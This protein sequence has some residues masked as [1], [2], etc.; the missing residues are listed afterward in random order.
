MGGPATIAAGLPRRSSRWK[1]S[2]RWAHGDGV[3]IASA[4]PETEGG[5]D[6]RARVPTGR[7]HHR[8]RQGVRA[9][10]HP[11]RRRRPG[12]RGQRSSRAARR[13]V[14][15]SLVVG[16]ARRRGWSARMAG[17]GIGPR[18]VSFA[19]GNVSLASRRG[20]R[21]VRRPP[22]G[23]GRRG[24][25]ARRDSNRRTRDGENAV[26]ARHPPG[27]PRAGGE[28]TPPAVS[29][30]VRGDGARGRRLGI[31]RVSRPGQRAVRRRSCRPSRAAE[32]WPTSA[33]DV[34]DDGKRSRPRAVF[35]Q[36]A[37]AALTCAGTATAQP[38]RTASR[39]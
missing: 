30:D 14:R 11:R 9:E 8:R 19:V 2:P 18:V 1:I 28:T 36:R 5:D 24:S 38:S 13:A 33:S 12:R 29:R 39:R 4:S 37:D 17:R 26:H 21:G 22:R 10:T 16:V 32:T 3:A 25:D 27:K 20:R 35:F 31:R 15:V 34:D 23:D 6:P 7:S